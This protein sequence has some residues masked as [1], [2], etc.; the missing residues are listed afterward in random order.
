MRLQVVFS[1][2]A[3]LSPVA[4]IYADEVNH[5]DFHH[6]LLGALSLD[7]T[8]FLK[9]SSSSNA[10]LLYTISEKSIVGAVNPR[11]GSLIWRQDLSRSGSS[12]VGP[13]ILRG[14]DGNNA[15]VSAVGD[16]VASWS[17]QDGK[18]VWESRLHDG[19]VADLE[20]L[21]LQDASASSN[22]RD[23]IALTSNNGAG[24]VRRLDGDLGKIK[25]EHKD[26]SGDIPFQVS[27]SPTEVFYISLQPAL[28]KGYRI[29]VTALD[30]ITGR[31]SRH[32]IL[33]SEGDVT[34][35]ESV[36]FVGA[37]TAS[38]LIA[39]ADKSLKS[40]KV[41]VIGTKHINTLAIDNASGLEIE[42]I[43]VHAPQKLNSLAHFL[44]HYKTQ[45]GAWAEVYHV[46]M[47]SSVVTKAYNLPYLQGQSVIATNNINANVYFTR[48]TDTEALVVS[49]ASHGILGRWKADVATSD[50]ILHAVA[51]VVTK[52][53]TVAVRSAIVHESGDWSLIRNGQTEWTRPEALVHTLA[54]AWAEDEDL[55][56]LAHELEIEGHETLL[57]AYVHR[58]KR[59]L[60]DLQHFPEWVKDLPKRIITSILSDEVSNLDSFGVAQSVIL[61]TKKGRIYA[62]DTGRHGVIKWSIQAEKTAHWDVKAVLTNPGLAEVYLGDGSSVR[63]NST[64]GK[65]LARSSPTDVKLATVATIN[66]QTGLAVSQNRAVGIREDGSPVAPLGALDGFLVTTSQDGRLL[67]WVETDSKSPVWDF[68]PPAGQRVV[69]AVSRPSHDPVASIGKVLGDRSVLYK[70]LNPNLVL[71]TAVNEEDHTAGFYLLDG[72]S[73][74]VLYSVSR[75][76]VDPTQPITSAISENWFAY[77]FF[78][79]AVGESSAKG[80]QLVVSELYESPIANDRGPLGSAGN[81]SSLHNGRGNSLSLPHVVSQSFV[82]AEPISHMAVTQTRQGITVRQLLCVLPSSNA[83]VGIPRQVL[84]PRRPVDRDATSAEAEEG[85]FRYAPFLEFD[86]RWY[87]THSRDVTGIKSILT[88]STLLE[89]TGLVFAYGGDI[90][91]TRT[92][93]SQAFDILGKSFSKLQLVLT[94]VAL[95]GGVIFLAPLARAKQVN[96][97]WK[98]S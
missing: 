52:G 46:D 59:H 86:G 70:Y 2:A 7:S 18:L 13:A 42:K 19:V 16:S 21:E 54:A 22:T 49:S 95:T 76:G 78:G 93:P 48:V 32:V 96:M 65:I 20:L 61:A 98:S 35:Q 24:V 17:A 25:W 30:P 57:G 79:D 82:I 4:A 83:I 44:V 28:L 87:L 97:L 92:T 74:K 50:P 15:V 66:Q 11:D 8:F 81:Y 64:T 58:V 41:N 26:T 67:G 14:L 55:E 73:G 9:P 85:L 33:N 80:Y 6:A 68:V 39:W 38:P 56:D 29:K 12:P 45:T 51:D 75:A 72:V 3:C 43:T 53:K 10:S 90:F 34:G 36:F 94:V 89:S 62:L 77:S 88:G 63:V 60:R 27:S 31:Q 84:D 71:V 1:I 69:K 91:G 37:N 23:V 47:K 40:L 5:I